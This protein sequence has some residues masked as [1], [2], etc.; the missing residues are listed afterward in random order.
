MLGEDQ[1]RQSRK[2]A[3]GGKSRPQT[4]VRLGRVRILSIVMPL[5]IIT[6]DMIPGLCPAWFTML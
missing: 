2:F 5:A 4:L 1:D 3:A 6:V